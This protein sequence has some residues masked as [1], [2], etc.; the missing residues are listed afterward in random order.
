MDMEGAELDVLQGLPW[1]KVVIKVLSIEVFS[2]YVEPVKSYMAK[3]GYLYVKTMTYPFVHDQIFVRKDVVGEL[4]QTLF[5]A[6]EG[7]L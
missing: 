3:V 1:D 7:G 5:K 4:N 6:K 2:E